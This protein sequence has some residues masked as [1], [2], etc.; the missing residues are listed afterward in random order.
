VK[1]KS[2]FFS[3]EIVIHFKVRLNSTQIFWLAMY[4]C[5][6]LKVCLDESVQEVDSL[7]SRIQEL[8]AQLNKEDGEYKR[9]WNIS[10][11]ICW[12]I[13]YRPS[14]LL[15][16]F[17]IMLFS[18]LIFIYSFFYFLFCF[19][20]KSRITSRIRKFVRMHNQKLELQDELKRQVMI[21][22]IQSIH[23]IW[24]AL[25]SQIHSLIFWEW[26]LFSICL[27]CM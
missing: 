7:N 12:Y 4:K 18:F 9:Y 24:R 5:I 23:I 27:F 25:F 11:C 10:K 21:L 26:F 20:V 14:A 16:Q 22:W 6:F 8:E 2:N 17:L 19:Y 1:R 3:V 13:F 15:W